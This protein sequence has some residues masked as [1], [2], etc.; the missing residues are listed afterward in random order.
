MPDKLSMGDEV[1]Y[2]H[3]APDGLSTREEMQQNGC[4]T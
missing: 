3:T 4:N 1:L 2:I